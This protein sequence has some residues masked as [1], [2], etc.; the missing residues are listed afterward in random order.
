MTLMEALHYSN[1]RG[2]GEGQKNRNDTT[3]TMN[4]TQDRRGAS[5]RISR[6]SQSFLPPCFLKDH[7]NAL[8]V[9]SR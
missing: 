6:S 8:Y 3:T 1:E 4:R 9:N 2:A 5:Q 7:P